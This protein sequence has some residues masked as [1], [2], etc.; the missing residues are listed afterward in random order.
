[1][2]RRASKP[3]LRISTGG[4]GVV[5]FRD[6]SFVNRDSLSRPFQGSRMPGGL[7]SQDSRPG[8][9]VGPPPSGAEK[10]GF[11]DWRA[12]AD[13]RRGLRCR[14]GLERVGRIV[15]VRVPTRQVWG[16][17]ADAHVCR[18]NTLVDA[19]GRPNTQG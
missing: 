9:I 13:W 16:C 5:S 8:L 15:S 17:G 7:D 1:M 18:I 4:G 6:S 19:R 2:W 12:A 14:L 11:A 10:R 3:R